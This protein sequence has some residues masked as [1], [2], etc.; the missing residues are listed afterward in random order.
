[1]DQQQRSTGDEA[2]VVGHG[3]KWSDE[4]LKQAVTEVQ[5]A[6]ETLQRLGGDDEDEVEGHGYKWS[7]AELKQAVSSLSNALERLKEIEK[8]SK[9]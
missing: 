8:S 1:M 5:S 4:N 2:E 6:L 9:S 7:D 3:Y